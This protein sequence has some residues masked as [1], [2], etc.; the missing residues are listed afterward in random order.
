MSVPWL[1][2]DQGAFWANM[3]ASVDF[4]EDVINGLIKSIIFGTVVTWIA[5]YQGFECLPTAEGISRATTRTVVY[6]SLWI[7]GLDFVLT[8]V[9]FGGIQ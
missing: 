1:G 5:V 8:A 2:A 6:A 3:Q 9:M 4:Y 7:L